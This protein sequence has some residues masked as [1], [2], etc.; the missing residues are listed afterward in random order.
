MRL[1]NGNKRFSKENKQHGNKLDFAMIQVESGDI[2]VVDWTFRF[3]KQSFVVF[4]WI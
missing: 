4:S 2:V 1:T 3:G